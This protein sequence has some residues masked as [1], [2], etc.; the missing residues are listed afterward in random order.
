[1]ELQAVEPEKNLASHRS[2]LISLTLIL[3]VLLL[4]KKRTRVDGEDGEAAFA[5]ELCLSFPSSK[6]LL[7]SVCSLLYFV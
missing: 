2:L 1:M 4:S 3:R 6:I 7:K 5:T